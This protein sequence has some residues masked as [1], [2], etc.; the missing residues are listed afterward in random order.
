MLAARAR[1]RRERNALESGVAARL[2]PAGRASW[3]S[4]A[5]RAQPLVRLGV[6]RNG[7]LVRANLG[8]MAL[9]GAY[10]GFQFVA[11][12]YL[13]STLGWSALETALAFLPGG[14]LVAF[15]AP[16]MGDGDQ[17]LRHDKADPGLDRRLRGR[18]RALPAG[19]RDPVLARVP[20][21]DAARSAWASRSATPR[22]NV[23][24]TA[25]VADHE[26]GLAAGLVQTSFQMGGAVVPRRGDARSSSD[27]VP[28][29]DR[30]RARRRGGEHRARADRR[31][32]AADRRGGGYRL[33]CRIGISEVPGAA[34]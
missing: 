17:P 5:G 29:R 22:S 2:A 9:F 13:Q 6:L 10:V 16:R 4:S 8:A 14:L 32:A 18:L 11:T 31:R 30:R 12:L 25:G 7:P 26:Q 19:R 3:W 15:G 24:A 1:A 23:Q 33:T 27:G 21:D 20:A 28:D 34:S